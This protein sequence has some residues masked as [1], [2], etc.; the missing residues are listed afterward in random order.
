[1]RVEFRWE[2]RSF[3][4]DPKSV[5]DLSSAVDFSGDQPT[6]FGL[7][8]A[9]QNAVEATGFVGDTTRGGGCNCRSLVLCPHGNGTHTESAQHL[10]ADAPAPAQVM[11]QPLVPAYLLS[12]GTTTLEASGESY[13]S[14]G[15]ANDLVISAAGLKEAWTNRSLPPAL[16]LRSLPNDERKR[17]ADY[18][19]QWAPYLTTEAI[20]WLCATGIEHLIVDLPSIDR[21]DDGGAL[22]NHHRLWDALGDGAT[23]TELA[24]VPNHALD[25]IYLLNLQLPHL[26]TD[27]VPSRPLLLP[28]VEV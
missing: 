21:H 11:T 5:I 10:R 26:L 15:Q 25:G 19:A 3:W 23:V 22:D 9:Q 6:F 1:M 16:V 2:G 14:C 18:D 4:A 28:A 12:V 20:T 27:A 24:Y 7:P 17:L 13:A 8:R